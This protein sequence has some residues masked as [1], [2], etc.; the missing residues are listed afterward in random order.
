MTQQEK[1]NLIYW[2]KKRQNINQQSIKAW[3]KWDFVNIDIQ[4]TIFQTKFTLLA[5]SKVLFF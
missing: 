2:N 5:N 1:N 4:K 3:N